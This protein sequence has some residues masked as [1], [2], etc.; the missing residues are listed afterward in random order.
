MQGV[1]KIYLQLKNLL[2]RQLIEYLNNI[3]AKY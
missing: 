3:Y 1:H 2:Q